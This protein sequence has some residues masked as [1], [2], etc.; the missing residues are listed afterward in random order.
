M[1]C[2]G[3]AAASPQA[4]HRAPGGQERPIDDGKAGRHNECTT[5]SETIVNQRPDFTTTVV[6][7]WIN[8][9][10]LKL[11]QSHP[12]ACPEDLLHAFPWFQIVAVTE[13]FWKGYRQNHVARELQA[14]SIITF[15]HPI[16]LRRVYAA[17]VWHALWSR[18]GSNPIQSGAPA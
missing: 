11:L 7:F 6:K 17:A 4:S 9:L 5:M 16:S 13:D 10:Y 14:F 2:M 1:T 18:F 15:V 8:R 3:K 12:H